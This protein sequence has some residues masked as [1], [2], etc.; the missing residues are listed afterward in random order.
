MPS[1][2]LSVSSR[3]GEGLRLRFTDANPFISTGGC[4]AVQQTDV[5]PTVNTASSIKTFKDGAGIIKQVQGNLKDLANGKA[6][7]AQQG[8]L[9]ANSDKAHADKELLASI[10]SN[11]YPE[12]RQPEQAK[13]AGAPQQATTTAAASS[14]PTGALLAPSATTAAPAQGSAAPPQGGRQGGGQ[15]PRPNRGGNGA[16][17]AGGAGAGANPFFPFPT[18]APGNNG[19][20]GNAGNSFKNKRDISNGMRWARRFL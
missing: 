16:G 1:L 12:T 10:Q 2:D 6:A 8:M 5:E 14:V 17:R 13:G 18:R 19:N 15:V 4:F 20:S 9:D 11:I 3:D 7:N